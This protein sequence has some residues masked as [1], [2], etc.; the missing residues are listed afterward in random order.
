VAKLVRH[1]ACADTDSRGYF[2]QVA[3]QFAR[4]HF[5]PAWAGQQQSIGRKGIECAEK[6]QALHDFADKRVDRDH[7]F[8]LGFAQRDLDGPLIWPSGA[9]TIA[10]KVDAFADAHAGMA[11]Q[12]HHVTGEIVTA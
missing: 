11:K 1:D 2:A 6:P 10:R 5:S 12:Q 9:E 4:Q 7:A 8:G 3:T